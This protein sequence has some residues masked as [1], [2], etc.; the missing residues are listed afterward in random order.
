MVIISL[1]VTY[2]DPSYEGRLPEAFCRR[3][4]GAAPAS[5]GLN[6]TFVPGPYSGSL[7]GH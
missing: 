3:G 1:G 7:V 6:A 2:P 4:T 5:E